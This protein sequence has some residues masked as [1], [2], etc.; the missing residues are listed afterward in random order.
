MKATYSPILISVYTRLD[1]LKQCILSLQNNPLSKESDLFIVSDAAAKENDVIKVE[2]VRQYVDK[3]EGFRSV[4]AINR[5]KNLGSVGSIRPAAMEILEKFGKMIFLEDDN[6]VAP[7][8]LKF[9]NDGL[10]FYHSDPAVF[11]ISG[12]TY[13]IKIPKSYQQDIYKWQ[14]YSAWGVGTWYDRRKSI[15]WNCSGAK[16]LFKD[17]S[18]VK[19]FIGKTG[20]MT[21]YH[22]D[23]MLKH[24]LSWGDAIISYNMFIQD[25]YSIFPTVSKVRN[26]GHDGLGEHSGISDRFFNQEIDEGADYIFPEKIDS[27][28]DIDRE[29]RKYFKVPLKGKAQKFLSSMITPQQKRWLKTLTAKRK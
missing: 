6:V 28:R 15:D 26:I 5:S 17:K 25:S 27:D 21:F 18:K 11:S 9:I 24:N 1:H 29:L 14:G 12:Y 23:Y 7:N 19:D 13:P 2:A 22:L 4:T 20:E 10:D 8:F 16:E 3:I